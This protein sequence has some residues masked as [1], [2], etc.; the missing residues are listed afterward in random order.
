MA[1]RAR[2]KEK[3]ARHQEK[4]Y[5]SPKEK[6]RRKTTKTTKSSSQA[7]P[8]N[9]EGSSRQRQKTF[10]G[11]EV[12]N[13][14][15]DE[16]LE[17]EEENSDEADEDAAQAA[18]QKE[19]DEESRKAAEK[20]SQKA[21]HQGSS[22]NNYS[23]KNKGKDPTKDQFLKPLEGPIKRA[24]FMVFD[25]ESKAGDS[26]EPGFT[27]PFMCGFYDGKKFRAFRNLP[28]TKSLPWSKRHI[29]KG[30]CIDRFLNV[31]FSKSSGYT[32]TT[33]Y[34]H[35]G[36]NFDFLFLLAWLRARPNLDFDIVPIQSTIQVLKVWRRGKKKEGCWT[37]LDSLKLLP[38]SLA[39]ACKALGL[40]GKK[41]LSLDTHE[42]SPLWEEYNGQ[43]CKALYDVLELTHDLVENKLGGEVG[44]TTPST[45]MK[46]FRRKY[47]AH[48]S[49]P[50]LIPRHM[51]FDSCK[52]KTSVP[53]NSGMCTGCLHTWVRKGY[54]GGRT[55]IFRMAGV[56]LKY[57][58]LN[59]SYPAS[60]ML[61]IPGGNK[62]ECDTYEPERYSKNYVGFVECIVHIPPEC[63]IPPLPFRADSGKLLFPAGT[64]GGTWST[65]ELELLNHPR[66]KGHVVSVTKCIWYRRVKIFVDMVTDLYKYRDKS[67]PGYDL[68]L[69][70]LAKLILNALYGKFG[71]KEERETIVLVREG[72]S[73]PDD[74]KP[75]GGDTETGIWYSTKISSPS[76]VIPQIAAHITALARVRLWHVMSSALDAGGKLYYC[77]TDS[78]ITDVEL[79]TD[80]ALGAL[81]DEFPGEPLTMEF[82]Q[83]KV[84]T[85][86][87]VEPFEKIHTP[88]CKNPTGEKGPNPTCKGCSNVK[89]TM[90]GLPQRERTPENM[91]NLRNGGTV[92]FER[93]EK[94][95]S[96]ARKGF[97]TSPE[98]VDVKKRIVSEYDKRVKLTDGGT[99]A[100]V[101]GMGIHDQAAE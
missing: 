26:Q 54:Y 98:M 24:R 94:I 49:A 45:A 8:A 100:I 21:S 65:E 99:R 82:M 34:A 33:I 9:T 55:E 23:N 44:I 52:D 70:T 1:T 83:P 66:V 88:E 68:G 75:A 6:T 16:A 79:P 96:L 4:A 69:S 28:S 101:L 63:E 40:P 56:N 80:S 73:P 20:T 61:D 77:D 78:V 67:L 5:S 36:G 31:L 27:R 38:M 60:M 91:L 47:L 11:Q 97:R 29:A 13:E 25:I 86:C 74:A 48:G 46:L 14:E 3:K 2:T 7:R 90:K 41:E 87:K 89:I 12:S 35:N 18:A 15:I 71:M 39:A 10:N 53:P 51:H 17:V 93:L 62:V 22:A 85:I 59:S 19:Y 84:Y 32:D 30:G 81:K 76:Y 42:G 72:E 92:Q 95:R 50:T 43:D 58:D 57:Y 37:F 64:F